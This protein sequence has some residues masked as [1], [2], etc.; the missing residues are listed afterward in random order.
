MT[1]YSTAKQPTPTVESEARPYSPSWVDYVIKWVEW[2]PGPSW[3]F[4]LLLWLVLFLVANVIKW[5]DGSQPPG[6]IEPL[7]ALRVV[8]GPYFLAL[9]H[10]LKGAADAALRAFRPALTVS[11]AEYNRLY[12][13]LTMLPARGA[14]LAG[15]IGG[16]IAALATRCTIVVE[17]ID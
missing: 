10:Y 14:L 15:G 5:V 8:Q 9:M 16:A 2:L 13:Q 1:K 11:E 4:Y 17:K 12:H 7:W 3:L 6:T